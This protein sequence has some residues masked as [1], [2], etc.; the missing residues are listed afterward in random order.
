MKQITIAGRIGRDAEL[1]Y[2]QAGAAVCRFS[3]ATDSKRGGEKVTTWFDV[4][5]FG[6]RGEALCSHL[7][8]GTVVC[9]V[10]DLDARTYEKNGETRMALGVVASEI[11]LL[12][13]GERGEQRDPESRS[14]GSYDRAPYSD[15]YGGGG[16]DP[17]IPFAPFNQD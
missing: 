8:K 3:V 9:V 7:R 5:I 13:G 10:G 14:G 6:K 16:G 11:T 17:D 4:S 12:G 1:K 15:D 2:T